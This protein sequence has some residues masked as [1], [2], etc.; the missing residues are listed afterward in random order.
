MH[1][2][3]KRLEFRGQVGWG[4]GQPM[5]KGVGWRYGIWNSQKVDRVGE[6]KYVV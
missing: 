1:L 5:E 2:T 6:I 4:W 3:L